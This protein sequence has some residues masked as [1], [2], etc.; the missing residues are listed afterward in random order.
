[1]YFNYKVLNLELLFKG[2]PHD[3][4]DQVAAYLGNL[5]PGVIYAVG[6]V[7][8]RE[9]LSF[10][11]P[12]IAPR[13]KQTLPDGAKGLSGDGGNG[14]AGSAPGGTVTALGAA[15]GQQ[16]GGGLRRVLRIKLARRARLL[17]SP[18]VFAEPGQG[19]LAGQVDQHV[20]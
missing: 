8:R 15:R 2:A 4:T 3:V 10:R 6:Y 14:Y 19:Y 16:F 11:H 17:R 7:S 18:R 5:T 20:G 1:M 9:Y 13:A 12:P